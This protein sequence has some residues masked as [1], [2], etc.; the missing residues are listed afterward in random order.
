[1]KNTFFNHL[2]SNPRSPEKWG[3]FWYFSFKIQSRLLPVKQQ[4]TETFDF[5]H[6]FGWNWIVLHGENVFR[7]V[8]CP[9]AASSVV[10]VVF[11]WS[12]IVNCCSCCSTVTTCSFSHAANASGCQQKRGIKSHSAFFFVVHR[13]QNRTVL[14]LHRKT[15]LRYSGNQLK[16]LRLDLKRIIIYCT[17]YFGFCFFWLT[18]H[19]HCVFLCN[20]WTRSI[21][22]N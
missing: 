14:E 8:L 4:P 1:M 19:Q 15:E 6:W 12:L 17:T 16:Q 22:F 10:H 5:I 20:D 3:I 9:L 11:W 13:T 2:R 21:S 18:K 7:F